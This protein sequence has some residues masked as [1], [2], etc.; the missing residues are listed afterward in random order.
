MLFRSSSD[1]PVGGDTFNISE[2]LGKMC[3]FS[4]CSSNVNFRFLFYCFYLLN[5][6]YGTDCFICSMKIKL[7]L[8]VNLNTASTLTGNSSSDVFVKSL[9]CLAASGMRSST[10]F[11]KIIVIRSLL[12]DGFISNILNMSESSRSHLF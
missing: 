7:Q 12:S 1:I 6:V 10:F 5:F 2:R 8:I 9:M 3:Y 11:R 4:L